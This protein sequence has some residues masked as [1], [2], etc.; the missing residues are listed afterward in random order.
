MMLIAEFPSGSCWAPHSEKLASI[1]GGAAVAAWANSEILLA[2]LAADTAALLAAA[3]ELAAQAI[4]TALSRSSFSLR[5]L[6][7]LR[8]GAETACDVGFPTA[9]DASASAAFCGECSSLHELSLGRESSGT[10]FA[11]FLCVVASFFRSGYPTPLIPGGG[12][13]GGVS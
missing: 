1:I 7:G 3:A 4:S 11:A 6:R 2:N 12:K 8:I 10:F 5:P 13:K 9:L